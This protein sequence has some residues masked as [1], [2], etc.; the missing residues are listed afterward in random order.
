MPT[1]EV[2]RKNMLGW[3]G[4]DAFSLYHGKRRTK[5]LAGR[6]RKFMGLEVTPAM[7]AAMD[8]EA[9][10]RSQATVSRKMDKTQKALVKQ[11]GG[12]DKPPAS[13]SKP[14]PAPKESKPPRA[15]KAGASRTTP[16]TTPPKLHPDVTPG[17]RK[18]QRDVPQLGAIGKPD[19]P[20]QSRLQKFY[21]PG[22]AKRKRLARS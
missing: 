1:R 4:Y 15:P 13:A 16:G 10:K 2:N 21:K 8:R 17:A 12:P 5:A 7:Q 19:A 20:T 9:K 22:G 18:A 14:L 6:Y 11:M 3:G